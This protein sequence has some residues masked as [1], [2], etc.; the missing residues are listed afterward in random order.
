MS[1]NYRIIKEDCKG[2][3][4]YSI[5]AVYYEEDKTTPRGWSAS[6]SYPSGET[7]EELVGDFSYMIKAFGKPILE[8]GEND[9][10][11]E[12]DEYPTIDLMN[13]LKGE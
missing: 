2:Y 6:H 10:L 11:I 8:V 12:S 1:W 5:R 3:F 9:K 13:K 4:D 7:F